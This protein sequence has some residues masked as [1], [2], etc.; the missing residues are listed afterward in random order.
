[1]QHMRHMRHTRHTIVFAPSA[2]VDHNLE[3]YLSGRVFPLQYSQLKSSSV[4]YS[5]ASSLRGATLAA[6]LEG[7]VVDHV[8]P[9]TEAELVEAARPPGVGPGE[10]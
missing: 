8:Q 2:C 6:R 4:S 9:E 10:G 1:M 7:A 5:L 3:T